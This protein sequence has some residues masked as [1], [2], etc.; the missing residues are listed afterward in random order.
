MDRFG[1]LVRKLA[2]WLRATGAWLVGRR[3]RPPR[4]EL[5]AGIRLAGA[6]RAANE[7]RLAEAWALYRT[8]PA[9]PGLHPEIYDVACAL[10]AAGST[11]EA[12]ELFHRIVQADDAFRDVAHRL[13]RAGKDAEQPAQDT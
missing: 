10:E 2:T 6:R 9:A 5:T 12:A 8:L 4:R 3:A 1:S 7:G 11:E 13:V